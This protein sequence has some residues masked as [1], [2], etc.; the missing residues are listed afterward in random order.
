MNNN[1]LLYILQNHEN[2]CEHYTV[3]C[4]RCELK[5]PFKDV[6]VII[7]MINKENK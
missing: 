6:E 7:I 5:M 1:S 2:E 3:R 4:D